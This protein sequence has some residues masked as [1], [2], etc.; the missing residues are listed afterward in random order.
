MQNIR[1]Y[2]DTYSPDNGL[3][4][5][6]F[7]RY[8]QR[9]NTYNRKVYSIMELLGDIG[10]LQQALVTIGFMFVT[11]FSRRIFISQIMR[12]IYQTKFDRG[13]PQQLLLKK[14]F[15]DD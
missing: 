1:T 12:E 6:V 13:I 14:T 3:I 7:I 8:D 9:Y 4:A 2:D 15:K 5:S 10:G 11:F